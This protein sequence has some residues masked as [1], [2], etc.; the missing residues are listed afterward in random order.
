MEKQYA[1]QIS[2]SLPRVFSP[3]LLRL[4]LKSPN[5]KHHHPTIIPESQGN[6]AP[7]LPDYR[8]VGMCPCQCSSHSTQ[9]S[10]IQSFVSKRVG[11][12]AGELL[13]GD[14]SCQGSISVLTAQ[15]S[16]AL[17]STG[18]EEGKRMKRNQ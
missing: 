11:F 9:S 14:T 18:V 16:L 13:E 4:E 10:D 7:C 2:S 3:I 17:P 12:R 5:K 8:D 6:L 15:V 1:S